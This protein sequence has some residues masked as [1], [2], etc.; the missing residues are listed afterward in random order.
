MIITIQS[1]SG[2]SESRADTELQRA[3]A[4]LHVAKIQVLGGG[5]FSDG[6]GYIVLANDT[7]TADGLAALTRVGMG[8]TVLHPRPSPKHAA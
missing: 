2:S 7:D 1:L 6:T 3:F 8:A 5:R 4:V